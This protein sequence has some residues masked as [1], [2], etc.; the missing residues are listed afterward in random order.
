M[1]LTTS[2]TLFRWLFLLLFWGIWL[3]SPFLDRDLE[4]ERGRFFLN[5]IFPISLTNVPL[6]FINTEVLIPRVL[7]KK[8]SGYYIFSLVVLIVVFFVLQTNMREW[9]SGRHPEALIGRRG[10]LNVFTLLPVMFATAV[11]TG[12]GLIRLMS[13]QDKIRQAEKEERL[14]SE[15][16]FL[17]SQISPH[18]I[19]NVLNG[20]VYLIR[21]KSEQAEKVTIQLSELMRYMLYDSDGEQV[22][23]EKELKYLGNYIQLQRIRFEDDVRI[24]FEVNGLVNT[25]TIEPMLLIPFVENAFKHGVGMIPD[26]VIAIRVECDGKVLRYSVKNK[27]GFETDEQKDKSSGIGLKNVKR[28]L[29]LLY[30]NAHE[31]VVKSD[32]G[33]FEIELRLELKGRFVGRISE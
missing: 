17:R 7:L 6:F 25:Q 31:F 1:R 16:A 15:L 2:D 32:D 22:A 5:V 14:Q 21:A 28:R 20:I 11:S 23:L 12:Y 18:F 24:D 19:F 4:T 3:F 9:L 8:G 13:R 27:I 33:W 26:P 30:P 29:E 10:V